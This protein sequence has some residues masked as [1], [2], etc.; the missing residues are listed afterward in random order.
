MEDIVKG[1]M[2]IHD[3][4]KKKVDN[5]MLS[6]QHSDQKAGKDKSK[7]KSVL[8][9]SL[10]AVAGVLKISK[11]WSWHLPLINDHATLSLVPPPLNYKA[12]AALAPV[13]RL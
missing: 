1:K 7:E 12:L 6:I 13:G 9:K 8:N 3:F 4:L 5:Q 10:D 2:E 11:W